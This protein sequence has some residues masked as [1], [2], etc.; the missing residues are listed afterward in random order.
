MNEEL[1]TKAKEAKSAEEL[2]TIAKENNYP[3]TGERVK[4]LFEQFHESGE[5]SDEE[6]DMVAAAV[7]P[8]TPREGILSFQRN[9]KRIPVWILSKKKRLSLVVTLRVS[10]VIASI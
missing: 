1:I 5:L 4:E 8:S 7:E 3:L 10:V 9:R 6:L 2:L